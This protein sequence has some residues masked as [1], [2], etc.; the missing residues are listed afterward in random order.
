MIVWLMVIGPC[1]LVP[2]SYP[3][4][5]LYDGKPVVL[6]AG[7]MNFTTMIAQLLEQ[8]GNSLDHY[9]QYKKNV[10][11]TPEPFDVCIKPNGGIS[12]F[13]SFHRTKCTCRNIL[14]NRYLCLS[15]DEKCQINQPT[16]LP[17]NNFRWWQTV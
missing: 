3:L 11:K 17:V 16:K 8:K 2:G 10:W 12:A 4:P 7:W 15:L 9:K 13:T 6:L 5:L 14:L 1:L